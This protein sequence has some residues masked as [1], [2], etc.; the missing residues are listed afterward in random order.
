MN[1]IHPSVIVHPD[2]VMG[3]NN[4]IME[5]VI[6]R[7]GVEIGDN[8]F[9]GPYCIIGDVPEKIGWFEPKH[10]IEGGVRIGSDNRFTKQV[11]IDSGTINKTHIGNNSLFLKNAHVGHDAF[12]HSFVTLSCNVAIGGWSIIHRHC[13]FGLGAVVHQRLEIP[14][15]CMIG[16]NSTITKTSKLEPFRKYAG[17]P[18]RDIGINPSKF[19][20]DDLGKPY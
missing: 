18:V 13:N 7:D 11:T 17:S 16:M 9:I 5:G 8:N 14:E 2:V 4:V 15:G 1:N 12:V 3:E 20:H 6:I 19:I 10:P